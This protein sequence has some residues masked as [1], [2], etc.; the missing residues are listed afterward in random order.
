MF[1]REPPGMQVK[2]PVRFSAVGQVAD[3]RMAGFGQMDSYLVGPARKRARQQEGAGL[4]PAHYTENGLGLLAFAFFYRSVFAADFADIRNMCP[5]IF[6]RDTLNPHEIFL[7][8]P[9]LLESPA[10]G[11]ICPFVERK[12]Q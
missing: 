6:F 1:E 7:F 2:T 9:P 11:L 4:F 10:E 3:C 8:Y 5:R 12:D